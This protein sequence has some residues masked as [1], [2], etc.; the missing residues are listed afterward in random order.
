MPSLLSLD[1]R[2]SGRYSL[3]CMDTTKLK[4][5]RHVDTW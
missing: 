2:L 4:W 1:I 5:I 3:C